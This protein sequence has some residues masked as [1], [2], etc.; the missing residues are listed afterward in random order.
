VHFG[1]D[2]SPGSTPYRIF[3]ID[4]RWHQRISDL[5]LISLE[6]GVHFRDAFG[7]VPVYDLPSLGGGD[8]LRGFRADDV[9]ARRFW[10]E[11]PEVWFPVPGTLNGSGTVK[12]FL[13]QS[14]RM[15]VFIDAA[16]ASGTPTAIP[17]Y[18]LTGVSPVNVSDGMRW[19]PGAGIRFIRGNFALKLDWAYGRGQG[20]SGSGHGRAYLGVVQ[21]G[22]F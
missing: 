6:I 11:Q 1:W 8:S 12:K 21:N 17:A 3:S 16:G 7:N 4:A 10:S 13:E 18:F 20:Q 14:I 19:G 9:L 22:A 15:A 2:L 5:K